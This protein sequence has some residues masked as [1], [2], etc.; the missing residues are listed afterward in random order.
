MFRRVIM[1][2]IIIGIIPLFTGCGFLCTCNK[3]HVKQQSTSQVSSRNL[4]FTTSTSEEKKEITQKTLPPVK[5]KISVRP[6]KTKEEFTEAI[7]KPCVVYFDAA[8]CNACDQ[9]DTIFD[10]VAQSHQTTC[11]FIRVDVD[12]FRS[13]ATITYKLTKIPAILFF[14]DGHEVISVNRLISSDVTKKDLIETIEKA[15]HNKE[16]E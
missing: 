2:S 1:F 9:M 6:V 15:F 14:K 4:S 5:R 13:L 11:N 10:H 16:S 12:E 8:W 3:Q 7:S